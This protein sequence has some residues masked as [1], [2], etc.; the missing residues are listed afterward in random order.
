[1]RKVAF[2]VLRRRAIRRRRCSCSALARPKVLARCG[3]STILSRR[4][5]S[6]GAPAACV[7]RRE[8]SRSRWVRSASASVLRPRSS[9]AGAAPTRRRTTSGNA[10]VSP[11][12]A[13]PLHQ[14]WLASN[15]GCERGRSNDP[16]TLQTNGKRDKLS[17]RPKRTAGVN[18]RLL[19]RS[20]V[21]RQA[22]L[23]W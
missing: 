3:Q 9:S 7:A 21:G 5:R 18:V 20:Q 15:A 12:S 8:G 4:P 2:L 10:R 23:A 6:T 1:M 16:K 17:A 13:Q 11:R 14:G 19:R 22:V